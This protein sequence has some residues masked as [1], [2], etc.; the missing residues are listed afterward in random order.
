MEE[1]PFDLV[2]FK[3]ELKESLKKMG[4]SFCLKDP[5]DIHL[6]LPVALLDAHITKIPREERLLF[7]KALPL[8]GEGKK[9]VLSILL[10]DDYMVD[11][12]IFHFISFED[13]KE[14]DNEWTAGWNDCV[15]SLSVELLS[16][17]YQMKDKSKDASSDYKQAIEDF[18]KALGIKKRRR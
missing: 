8:C 11:N 3:D 15:D 18:A 12:P 14:E 13:L 6:F 16:A 2:V 10:L 9:D 5:G 4:F 17:Y 7:Y 1:I